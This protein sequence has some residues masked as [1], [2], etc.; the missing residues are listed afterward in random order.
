MYSGKNRTS[1]ILRGI[2]VLERILGDEL[3]EPLWI[4][5]PSQ[6][7]KME[8]NLVFDKSLNATKVLRVVPSVTAKS[9]LWGL[10]LRTL[11]IKA[12]IAKVLQRSTLREKHRMETSSTTSQASKNS[13]LKNIVRKSFTL[14]LRKCL[15]TLYPRRLEAHDQPIIREISE[16][17]DQDNAGYQELIHAIAGS[18]PFTE[19]II[20]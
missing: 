5:L 19:T 6:R 16:K 4:S 10:V 11:T 7:Q 1:P 3:S 13:W 12:S 15:L 9:T 8:R 14:S 2:W 17:L 20:R 18:L